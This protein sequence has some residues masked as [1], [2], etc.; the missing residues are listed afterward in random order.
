VSRYS[1]AVLR[2]RFDAE[3][4]QV[5]SD[6]LA[7]LSSPD[8][9]R[10]VVTGE[11]CAVYLQDSYSRFIRDLILHSS[12]GNASTAAGVKLAPGTPGVLRLSQ[13]LDFLRSRWAP[14]T[15]PAWWEPDWYRSKEWTIALRLLGPQ[16]GP[17][18]AAAL[19]S[20]ASPDDQLRKV[21]NFAVHRGPGS[22]R[23][24][25]NVAATAGVAAT[26]RQPSDVLVASG[27]TPTLLAQWCA[28]LRAVSN[29]AVS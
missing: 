14:T 24:I 4:N 3:I 15:K 2:Q 20:S 17:T 27:A 1:L 29:A 16:N 9:R 7:A 5:E 28:R 11:R 12:L 10:H 19:G 22:A 6:F 13:A 8:Q 21:R 25:A 18:I 26:W 23:G